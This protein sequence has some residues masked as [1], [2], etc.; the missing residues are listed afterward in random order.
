MGKKILFT[1]ISLVLMYNTY[2]LTTVFFVLPPEKFSL[3]AEIISAVA[4]NFL[5][6]GVVAFLGFVYPTNRILSADYYKIKNPRTIN[7]WYKILGVEYF[8]IFLLS[9][10]YRKKDNKKYFNGTKSGILLFEYNT[11]QSEFGHLIALI[12]VFSLSLIVLW[13]GHKDIFIWMQPLNIILNFYPI[14]LQ[15]KH[16]IITERIMDRI[17]N[18]NS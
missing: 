6:T 14:L 7:S 16:R 17:D 12:L 10:F 1:A 9:T 3:F 5:T 2:K 8:R 11:R 18:K 13:N 15:R 4:L